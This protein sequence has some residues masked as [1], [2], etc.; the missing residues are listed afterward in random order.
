M[1]IT[2]EGAT[3]RQINLHGAVRS[4]QVF[5]IEWEIN[6]HYMQKIQKIIQRG[7]RHERKI[8]ITY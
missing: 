4:L 2:K 3:S 6:S 7:E 5:F 1:N 8:S